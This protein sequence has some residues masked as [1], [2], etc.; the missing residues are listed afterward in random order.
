MDISSPHTTNILIEEPKDTEMTDDTRLSVDFNLG[1]SVTTQEDVESMDDS[2]SP[3][4][5]NTDIEDDEDSVAFS[6]MEDEDVIVFKGDDS[7]LNATLDNIF[8][9]LIAKKQNLIAEDIQNM[10]NDVAESVKSLE[11]SEKFMSDVMKAIEEKARESNQVTDEAATKK[12][13]LQENVVKNSQEDNEMMEVEVDSTSNSPPL[14]DHSYS[15]S[16]TTATQKPAVNSVASRYPQKDEISSS[17][18]MTLNGPTMPMDQN[19]SNNFQSESISTKAPDPEV[20]KDLCMKIKLQKERP[21][22]VVK[23]VPRSFTPPPSRRDPSSLSHPPIEPLRKFKPCEGITVWAM[24]LN[25]LLEPWEVGKILQIYEKEVGKGKQKEYVTQIKVKFSGDKSIKVVTPKQIANYPECSVR[26]PTGTRVIAVYKDEDQE[27]GDFFPAIIAE[28]PKLA[29]KNRYLV[30]FDDG[31]AS[32]LHHKDIRIVY[33]ADQDVWKDVD[34]NVRGFV[35]EY[36]QQIPNKYMITLKEGDKVRTELHG[37]MVEAEVN[38]IDGSLAQMVFPGDV[39]EWL[40]RGS[41][42]FEPMAKLKDSLLAKKRRGVVKAVDIPLMEPQPYVDHVCDADCQLPYPYE[43]SQHKTSNPLR[44]PL[45]LGWRREI[46]SGEFDDS[47]WQIIYTAPCGRRLRNLEEVHRYL[48]LTE[49]KLEIDMFAFDYWL[50]V[51]REFVPTSDF[52]QLRDI[53]HGKETMPI[54]AANSYDSAYPPNIE[55]STV[56]IPQK[57]VNI[58]TDPGFLIGCNCKNNCEDRFTC[59]CRQLTIKS[60]VGDAGGRENPEA[61]YVHRRLQDVVLT[62]IYEC[63]K[64]CKCSTTCV[65]RLVQFPI[66]SRLQI[67]RTSSCGW[68]VRTLDDLPQGAFIATYVGKLYGPEE[69]NAQGTA[70]GDMYFADLDMV[71]NIESRKEGYESDVTDIEAE[72]SDEDIEDDEER[73]RKRAERAEKR[74]RRKEEAEAAKENSENPE[75]EEPKFKSVRKY[76]GPNEESYIMDAMTQG[77][78]GRYLNHSCDPNVFVQNVFVDSHDLRFPTIAFFT[79]KYVPAGAELCWNYNYVVDSVEGKQINCNCGADNCKGRLL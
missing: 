34:K 2:A 38:D 46:L 43:A 11:E 72:D 23:E 15:S 75:S 29:N 4:G 24:K 66:R 27:S 9:D 54:S 13:K 78:V 21:P 47:N 41:A 19:L 36:I 28:N 73:K 61:G 52:I 49:S 77:N 3:S 7:T 5:S 69:G 30:F 33:E 16:Q 32:Y 60:T 74:K 62:G 17:N 65:N 57:E 12:I 10:R 8:T 18:I 71:D 40:Y 45:H 53:S 59:P 50:S 55:Y 79:L 67:F 48:D 26:I 68:G 58:Q 56:P 20:T 14:T 63:N 35:K 6:E 31:Y 22:I 39:C 76:F 42:R 37:K 1:K 25:S 51:M 44:I 70:F 64:T